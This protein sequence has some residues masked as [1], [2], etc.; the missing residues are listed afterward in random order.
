MQVEVNAADLKQRTLARFMRGEQSDSEDG[1]NDQ[2]ES[3]DAADGGPLGYEVEDVYA[4]N[5][6]E[7]RFRCVEDL[8]HSVF[9]D[10]VH[11]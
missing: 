2:E 11:H 1:G 10:H 8:K 9:V 5:R 3:D 4:A 7:V 6:S